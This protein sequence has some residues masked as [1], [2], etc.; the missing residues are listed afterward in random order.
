MLGVGLWA[1][2]KWYVPRTPIRSIPYSAVALQRCRESGQTVFIVS[3]DDIPWNMA[4]HTADDR[5]DSPELRGVV[6]RY[7]ICPMLHLHVYSDDSWKQWAEIVQLTGRDHSCMPCA[8]VVPPEPR[9]DVI[10][11][12]DDGNFDFADDLISVLES[13]HD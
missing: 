7:H 6:H 2:E 3:D 13:I 5:L 9:R 1:F 12:E 10:V 11:F 4:D 8:L